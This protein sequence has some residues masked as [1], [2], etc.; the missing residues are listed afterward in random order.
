MTSCYSE[1][2]CWSNCGYCIPKNENGWE[3]S[4]VDLTT[5]FVLLL[6]CGVVTF[7]TCLAAIYGWC[8]DAHLQINNDSQLGVIGIGAISTCIGLN[9]VIWV[10]LVMIVYGNSYFVFSGMY[11]LICK[12]MNI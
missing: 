12:Y 8:L 1:H 7:S 6:G 2:N 11:R 3:P 5:I 4:M 9:G 10:Y